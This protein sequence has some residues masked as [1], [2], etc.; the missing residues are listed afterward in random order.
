MR[1]HFPSRHCLG[2]AEAP[3]GPPLPA[4]S[5]VLRLCRTGRTLVL[6]SAP[7]VGRLS[8]C[9]SMF[10]TCSSSES[11]WVTTTWGCWGSS[12]ILFT[13]GKVGQPRAEA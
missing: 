10:H 1:L 5:G 9:R 13:W 3:A 11:V 8:G 7:P 4:P 6:F 2:V 12:R